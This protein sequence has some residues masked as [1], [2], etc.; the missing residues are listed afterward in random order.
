MFGYLLE[1]I[2]EIWLFSKKIGQI[3]A[4]ENLKK[5]LILDFLF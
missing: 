1:P 2:E 5:H 4:N 3:L